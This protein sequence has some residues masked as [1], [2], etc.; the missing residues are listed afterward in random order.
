[1][2]LLLL[3]LLLFQGSLGRLFTGQLQ[4]HTDIDEDTY[5]LYDDQKQLWLLDFPKQPSARFKTGDQIQVKGD[6]TK[7]TRKIAVNQYS[8][9]TQDATIATPQQR[10]KSPFSKFKTKTILLQ[11]C[12]YTQTR[13]AQNVRDVYFNN[14]DNLKDHIR[15]CSQSV[16]SFTDIDNEVIDEVLT[17]P[18]QGVYEETEYDL[19]TSC[20]SAETYAMNYHVK[21]ALNGTTNRLV[22]ILPPNSPCKWVGIANIG[23]S[24]YSCAAWINKIDV[25]AIFH[26][27]GHTIMLGHANE[28]QNGEYWDVSCSMGYCCG[29]RC[30]NAPNSYY[31][32][33]SE[34]MRDLSQWKSASLTLNLKPAHT[35]FRNFVVLD[36][37]YI[38]YRIAD[39][40][41]KGIIPDF[42]DKVLIHERPNV[43]YTATTLLAR[44]KVNDVYPLTPNITLTVQSMNKS[45]ARILLT[46]S[47]PMLRR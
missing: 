16:A 18:C 32:G 40:H 35:A 42:A 37:L 19:Q 8:L 5:T 4:I 43:V 27:L 39:G 38:S 26:E 45:R 47:V 15:N 13:T 9:M 29:M 36:N 10:L 20:T 14:P 22:M 25:T 44:L 30:F 41:D 12:N 2:L 34:P 7:G 33:W 46:R 23:C 1:M 31:V 3:T 17:I 28:K 6:V 11:Y 21:N 24:W